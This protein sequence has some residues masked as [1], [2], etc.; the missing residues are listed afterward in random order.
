MRNRLVKVIKHKNALEFENKVNDFLRD[1][2]C[3]EISYAY[4]IETA[5]VH[6]QFVAFIRYESSEKD[7]RPITMKP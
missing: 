6:E 7:Y 4:G 3:H 5:L 2:T 1:H